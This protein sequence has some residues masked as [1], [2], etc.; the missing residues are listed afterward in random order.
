MTH[1]GGK[2]HLVGDQGQRYELTVFDEEVNGRIKIGWFDDAGDA[3]KAGKTFC[4]RP[5]WSKP[6]VDDRW[7]DGEPLYRF[8]VEEVR[9]ESSR[10]RVGVT[11]LQRRF[12]IGYN[13]A[14]RIM[15][16]LERN[17]VVG[18]IEGD[19]KYPVL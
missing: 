17:E 19:G 9:R 7:K 16:E 5:S 14:A 15:E 12:N 13:R 10:G 11:D 2:N 6:Q 1:S 8:A 4:K 18:P 3:K